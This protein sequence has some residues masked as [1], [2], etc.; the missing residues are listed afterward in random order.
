MPAR[1]VLAMPVRAAVVPAHGA[2]FGPTD[3]VALGVVELGVE[4]VERTLDGPQGRRHRR[5]VLLG[6]VEASGRRAVGEF[7]LSRAGGLE[8]RL[9]L[10]E[11]GLERLEVGLLGV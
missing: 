7:R 11:G 4:R 9:S 1:A 2:P 3:A 5:E 10:A 8:V 6:K